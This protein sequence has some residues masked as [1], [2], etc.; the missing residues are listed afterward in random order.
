MGGSTAPSVA[1]IVGAV[2]ILDLRVSLIE[3]E[4]KIAAAVSTD[5]KAGEHIVLAFVG[6]ALADFAPLLLHLLKNRPFDDRLVDILEDDPILPVILQPLF[7][8]VGFGVGLE[9]E[10]ITAILLQ[11]QD[12]GHGGTVPLGRRL[13]LA[14]SGALNAL[15]QP[16]GTRGKDFIP[17]KLRGD[18]L[19]PVALQGH[20]VNPP[21]HL[22]GFIIY[23]PSFRIVGVFDVTVGRLAHRLACIPLD[24]V[25]DTPFLADVAG[26]PLIEQVADRRQLV[27][28]LGGVYVVRYRH[29]ANVMLREKFLG[30]SADLDVVTAQ[31]GKIFDK[32]C[33]GPPL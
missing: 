19:R 27:L 26:V 22:G 28:A 11:R 1:L 2:E 23:D 25:A 17:F 5:Q 3:V 24:L 14:L 10:N 20:A 18:L 7:V 9:V 6:A 16:I 31:A 21:N 29:Q 15:F 32:Y 4:V 12:F 8:L 33:G 13:L 30:Q